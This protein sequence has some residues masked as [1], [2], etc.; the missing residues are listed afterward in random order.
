MNAPRSTTAAILRVDLGA[1]RGERRPACRTGGR[2]SGKPRRHGA[3]SRHGA[4]TGLTARRRGACADRRAGIRRMFTSQS[5]RAIVAPRHA[6]DPGAPARRRRAPS[7]G[8]RDARR[9]ETTPE[10]A[11]R[12][13]GALAGGVRWLIADLSDTAEVSDEALAALVNAAREL[14][15]RRGEMIVAGLPATSP[16]ASAAWE[17]GPPAGAG[18]Q[19]RP[20]RDDPQD[21][22][23]QDGRRGARRSAPSSASRRSRCRASSPPQPGLSL[24]HGSR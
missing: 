4:R 1:Q 9:P 3:T 21:A 15:S 10:L 23:A 2:A 13:D 16:R 11:R 24:Q 22:A 6:L 8:P 14:R 17:V 18:G 7:R 5:L 20:G 19:R 12:I